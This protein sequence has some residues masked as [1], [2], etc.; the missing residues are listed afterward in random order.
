[1]NLIHKAFCSPPRLRNLDRALLR[2]GTEFLAARAVLGGYADMTLSNIAELI[3]GIA[4]F[5]FGMNL[6]GDNLKQVAGSR[7]EIVLYQLTGSAPKGV[8]FGAG[9]TA[10]IQSSSA[11]SVM[12][13]GFVN[14][15]VMS[16]KQAISVIL[17]AILGTSATGW[18]LCLS[19]IGESSG[20]TEIFSSTSLTAVTALVGILF[21]MVSK[22]Q[23]YRH[24]GNILIGFSVLMV[25]M[26]VMSSA[27]HPLQENE[28]FIE[29]L[30]SFSNPLLGIAA[31]TLFTAVLQSASAAVGI[32]Q[33]L[34][35]AGNL[36]FDV[37]F[38]LIMGIS[39]GAAV[40][41]LLAAVGASAKG[42]QASLFYLLSSAIGVVL[43]AVPF[44]VLCAFVNFSFM[45]RTLS[46]VDIALLNTL[47]RLVT[48]LLLLPLLPLLVRILEHMIP[49]KKVVD[50]RMKKL[51]LLEERLVQHPALA[52]E[53]CKI[54]VLDMLSL[55]RQNLHSAIALQDDYNEDGYT[56]IQ[57]NENIVDIYE[58]KLNSYMLK[59]TQRE[60][61]R[62]QNAEVSKYLH[63][64]S[65]FERLSDHAVNLSE[66]A[67]ERHAK[68]I[69]LS[70]IAAKELSVLQKA[71]K[72]II[73]LSFD[74]Y[75]SNNIMPAA[76][77]EA[78]EQTI[79]ALCSR[80]K[81][82]HIQRL[83]DGECSFDSG[84]YLNELLMNYK[85]VAS[86]CSNISVGMISLALNSYETHDYQEHIKE[87]R[88]SDFAA[89]CSMYAAEYGLN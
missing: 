80:I 3:S 30:T 55:A 66:L 89:A 46:S 54:V 79:D 14:A 74:G 53:Q 4:L 61:T 40:P 9:V 12:V 29:I 56:S 62:E 28:T 42:K 52:I 26:S 84:L 17:G 31:G 35:M 41:V 7:L 25:G 39:I 49:E 58:D 82:N 86:H 72:E 70:A 36:S 57:E 47:F 10:V 48:V 78:L 69:T 34:A 19:S 21:I 43:I 77:V 87:F 37:V 85:R 45:K 23:E 2:L 11:T 6:M 76:R 67:K 8:L 71:L 81:V 33:A 24:L 51:E 60:L 88:G 22:R 18:L 27:V 44:Y 68:A 50:S 59:I 83:Q 5:L 15:G 64:I 1:M 75:T 73:K 13:I 63:T 20:W 38:P 65:D 32:L 16:L